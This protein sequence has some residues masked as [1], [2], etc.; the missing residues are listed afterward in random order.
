V[1]TATKNA[2]QLLAQAKAQADQVLA[3]TKNEI[4]PHRAGLQREVDELT[5][6]KDSITSHLAQLRQM[7]GP[8][9]S[10]A[11]QRVAV[12]GQSSSPASAPGRSPVPVL[13]QPPPATPGGTS[14]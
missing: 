4:E 6:R 8:P 9:P 10:A 13:P 7:L 14:N 11:A 2:G 12:G 3:A 1:S 5:T